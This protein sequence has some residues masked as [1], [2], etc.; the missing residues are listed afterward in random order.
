M[1]DYIKTEE[2]SKPNKK[3]TTKIANCAS[4]LVFKHYYTENRVIFAWYE[5]V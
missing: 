4:Y 3:L 5:N 2:V 1:V